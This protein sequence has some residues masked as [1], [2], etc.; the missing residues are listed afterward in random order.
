[1]NDLIQSS[2]FVPAHVFSLSAVKSI[3]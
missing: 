2:Q 1:M 3:L